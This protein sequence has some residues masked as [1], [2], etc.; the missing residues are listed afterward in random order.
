MA[1]VVAGD[2]VKATA[3]MLLFNGQS[4]IENVF[5]FRAIDGP[6]EDSLVCEELAQWIDDFY[7]ELV[8][9]ITT[10][11]TFE[12]VTCFNV[13]TEQPMGSA[14]F[15]DT[16]AGS[17]SGDVL[18]GGVAA[19]ITLRTGRNRTLGRKYLGGFTEGDS[20]DGALY[21]GLITALGAAGALMLENFLGEATN[22]L[23][24]PG[25]VSKYGPF[26]SFTEA[27]VRNIWAYQRRRR[28]G[29]G[30]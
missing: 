19:L 17:L 1:E 23:W 21:T 27:V 28:P 4:T 10:N 22:V 13:S 14:L 2:F 7:K 29:T 3:R 30:I 25:I 20:N 15:P 18:P 26:W 8:A 12:D 11:L 5:Y 24:Q 16:A 9:K 6:G